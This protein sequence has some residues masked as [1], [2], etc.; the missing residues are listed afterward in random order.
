M[1]LTDRLNE[2]MLEKGVNRAEVAKGSG[3]PYTTIVALFDKGSD[4]IKLSN[5][6]KLAEYF[7]VTLDDLAGESYEPE[8]IAAHHDGEKW[9]EEE[10]QTIENFKRFVKQQRKTQE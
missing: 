2:L 3:I 10:L 4:N 8:T 7:E 6:R 9:T 5:L 1:P